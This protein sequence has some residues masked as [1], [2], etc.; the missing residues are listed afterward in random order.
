MAE[1]FRAFIAIELNED[2]HA[3]LAS[4]QSCLKS[5]EADVKWV[6]PESIHIT[7]KFLGNI[8]GK[9]VEE[10]KGILKEVA[11]SQEPFWMTL[12]EAGAFPKIDFPKVIW[13]G[14][15][16]G[17]DESSEI[18]ELLEERLEAIGIPREDR[19]F[20]PHATLG[21]AK[22]TKNIDRLKKIMTDLKFEP[23]AIVEVGGLIL[24]QS[25][26]ATKG[27]IYTPLFIAKMKNT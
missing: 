1:T 3:E 20:H 27:P 4:L 8:D 21:R 11:A 5:S 7:L 13:V 24:F 18:A 15:D 10:V 9:K 26:L 16:K 22:S 6:S 12:K 23:K 25:Q 17:K 19:P 2:A 14:I